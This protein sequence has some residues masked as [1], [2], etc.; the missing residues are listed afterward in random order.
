VSQSEGYTTSTIVPSIHSAFEDV[1][2]DTALVELDLLPLD[3]VLL[4]QSIAPNSEVATSNS[5][6][7]QR[8]QV[9]DFQNGTKEG[10][11]SNEQKPSRQTRRKTMYV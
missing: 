3:Q 6:C 5:T 10:I 8:Y 4:F 9:P 7:N 11:P 1:L 2:L